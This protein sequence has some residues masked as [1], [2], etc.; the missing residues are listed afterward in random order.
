MNLITEIQ[1]K[2]QLINQAIDTLARNGRKLAES[3]QVY[4]VALRQEMLL[5]RENGLP[6]TIIGDICRG[7]S[8]IAKL[9]FERDTAE[10]VYRANQEAINAWKLEVR[11]LESQIAR[12]WNRQD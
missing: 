12:E 4:R 3:E 1:N 8:H 6:V 2:M 10:A 11:I 9:K 7:A 5:E